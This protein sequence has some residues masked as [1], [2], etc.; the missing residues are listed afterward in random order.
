VGFALIGRIGKLVRRSQGLTHVVGFLH[1][2]INQERYTL[3]QSLLTPTEKAFLVVLEQIVGDRFHI[4]L[5][6]QLSHIVAPLDANKHFVNYHDFNRIKA[7]S[8][9]FVLYDKDYKPYLAIELDDYTHLR[10]DRVERDNF[11]DE[12]MKSVGLNIIH[13]PVAY[14]YD[15]QYLTKQIL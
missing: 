11:V 14:S 13:I 5:Q 6:V 4:E 2:M 8:I 12:V 1:I 15:I 7:K 3:R 9:D 10:A